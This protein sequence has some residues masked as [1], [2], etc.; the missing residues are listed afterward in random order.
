MNQVECMLH[1]TAI[2]ITLGKIFCR[3]YNFEG[4]NN[5]SFTGLSISA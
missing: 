4:K 5:D 2:M 3:K 1:L